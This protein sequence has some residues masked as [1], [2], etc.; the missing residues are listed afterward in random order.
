LRVAGHLYLFYDETNDNVVFYVHFGKAPKKNAR[1]KR[2]F[3]SMKGSPPQP[4]EKGITGNENPGIKDKA[5]G[6]QV[7]LI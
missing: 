2:Q 6:T 5:G 7:P 3:K 1:A 4:A